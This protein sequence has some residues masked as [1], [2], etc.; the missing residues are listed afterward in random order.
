M[1]AIL[2][3]VG[4]ALVWGTSDFCGGKGAQRASA[5]AVT[6]VSQLASIPV[7]VVGLLVVPGTPRLSDIGWGLL[8]G[9]VGLIG[10]VLLYRGLAGGAM[11]IF[12]PTTAVTAAVV[13]L[14]VGLLLD[15]AIGGVALAGVI[16]GVLAIGL[17][18]SSP[19]GHRERPTIGLIGLALLAGTM[20][21]SFFILIG[22]A[23]SGAGMWPL[24]GVRAAS[25]ALGL[26]IVARTRTSL[27]LPR[28][29][30]AWAL[31]A[32]PLDLAANALFMFAAMEGHLG[33]VAVLAALYPASTVLLALAVDKERVRLTQVAGLGLA[34]A[35]L[36]LVT[37]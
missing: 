21:G 12:S 18:S 16:C 35:S 5:L 29:S 26:L 33:I 4:S 3:A 1:I 34:A 15:G 20:F 31:P 6:V 27:R 30:L 25:L 36:V 10:I 11:V 37:T 23:S 32:G 8:G 2:L 28:S 22:Q 9:V 24:V 14:G 19:D 17:I 7:L 13:P